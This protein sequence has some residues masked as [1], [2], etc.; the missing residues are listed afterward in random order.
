MNYDPTRAQQRF[1]DE[2]ERFIVQELN[3]QLTP[4]QRDAP[5]N[6]GAWQ[7][8]ADEGLLRWRVPTAQGGLGLDLS[9]AVL[10]YEAFGKYCSDVSF[11]YA[12]SAHSWSLMTALIEFADDAQQRYLQ[13]VMSGGRIGA[14]A[15]TEADAGSDTAA[16]QS[17]AVRDGDEYV[18]NGSKA[19]ITL[20]PV[21]DFTLVFASTDPSRGAWGI[22]AFLVDR[23]A[24]GVHAG[25]PDAKIWLAGAPLGPLTLTDC[26]VPAS[27][28]VGA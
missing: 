27:A 3:P 16:I 22:S 25:D 4:D 24:P 1:L 23:D 2:L 10:G 11:S 14:F 21:A 5:F 18:L 12:F 6:R 9:T 26:R 20:A 17:R 15:M 19:Y 7:R 13:D 8:C 28:R